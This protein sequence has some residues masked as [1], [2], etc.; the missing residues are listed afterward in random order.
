MRHRR[1]SI[2]YAEQPFS[3]E[4]IQA[5]ES[6]SPWVTWAVSRRGE[7][8]GTMTSPPQITT[9]DFDVRGVLWLKEL[10]SQSRQ[11]M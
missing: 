1:R 9:K 3:F 10:L 8:I 4:R 11:T 2:V 6:D 7:F 5:Q